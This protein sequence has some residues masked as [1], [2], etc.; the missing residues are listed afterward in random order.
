MLEEIGRMKME[1]YADIVPLSAENFRQFCTGEYRR[2]GVPIG[3]KGAIFHRVIKD[4]MIQGG[5]FVNGDGTGV[6][7]VYGGNFADENFKLKHSG[8]GLLSL[9]NS[10]KDTNG[11]QF[12][13]TC[14]KCDFLDGKHV[15]F[16]R[17]VDG[18]LVM[19]KI[20]NVPIGPNNKPK[21]PVTIS[22]CGE[23]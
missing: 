16:G 14:A 1:L 8:P 7:S 17:V 4:F 12:F 10:G 21:I 23:M 9:A 13:V 11:C 6:F 3:Y 5:D 15:V 19:R 2:D 20:E 18:L 22:Q